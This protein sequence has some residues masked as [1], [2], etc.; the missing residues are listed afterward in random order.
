VAVRI[1]VGDK[2][3]E[4]VTEERLDLTDDPE[5]AGVYTWEG[6]GRAED[7]IKYHLTMDEQK[8]RLRG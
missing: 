7:L 2:Y 6:Q 4:F 5:K 8:G 1:K 3:V